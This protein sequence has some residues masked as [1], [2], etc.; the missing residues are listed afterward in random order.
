MTFPL[1]PVRW[2][3]AGSPEPSSD[4]SPA[5]PPQLC[6]Q[7]PRWLQG[8]KGLM[9]RPLAA[10]GQGSAML[11]AS[12]AALVGPCPPGSSYSALGANCGHREKPGGW[13][14]CFTPGPAGVAGVPEPRCNRGPKAA[15]WSSPE[16]GA[17]PSGPGPGRSGL[18]A[19]RKALRR[20]QLHRLPPPHLALLPV[21]VRLQPLQHRQALRQALGGREQD[22]VVKEGPQDGAD[23][24]SDPED[25]QRAGGRLARRTGSRN[26]AVVGRGGV[27]GREDCAVGAATRCAC[28]GPGTCPSPRLCLGK[29]RSRPSRL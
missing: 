28:L 10:S 23:Q 6:P 8:A 14:L 27:T 26:A 5:L 12:P 20:V 25:L 16:P 24:G 13:A 22:V 7:V 15:A 29:G 3:R 9:I 18:A 17:G 1:H 2:G 11:T 4:C 21:G 19:P